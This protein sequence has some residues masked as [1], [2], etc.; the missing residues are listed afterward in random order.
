MELS[1]GKGCTLE[2]TVEELDYNGNGV[3]VVVRVGKNMQSAEKSSKELK[4]F[5]DSVK[6]S[7]IG[8]NEAFTSIKSSHDDMASHELLRRERANDLV[9]LIAGDTEEQRQ[10]ANEFAVLLEGDAE[11]KRQKAKELVAK[12]AKAEEELA[13]R[14][15]KFG[16][17]LA[18]RKAKVEEDLAAKK[19]ISDT[20]RGGY[21]VWMGQC[22]VYEK[23]VADVCADHQLKRKQCSD[24]T[25]KTIPSLKDMEFKV[26][27]YN[28]RS[29]AILAEVAKA[30]AE[31]RAFDDSALPPL[32]N[33]TSSGADGGPKKRGR[34]YKVA[35]VV[36]GSA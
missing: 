25:R 8:L 26:T 21:K 11:E 35:S 23:S 27:M 4:Q 33:V 19:D 17:E 7:A 16:E 18:A 10:K 24:G 2:D 15:V 32:Y 20:V 6:N 36:S 34:P 9:A 22:A 1:Y 3:N 12:Q 13:A 5:V 31:N 14:K 28:N 29:L 30:S